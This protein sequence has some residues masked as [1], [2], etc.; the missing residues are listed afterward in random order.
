MAARLLISSLDRTNSDSQPLATAARNLPQQRPVRRPRCINC[1]FGLVV[2]DLHMD[3]QPDAATV[4]RLRGALSSGQSGDQ[5]VISQ[6][7]Y[8]VKWQQG[9]G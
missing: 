9:K 8:L 2:L 1:L 5:G 4:R 3:R 6:F 7:S